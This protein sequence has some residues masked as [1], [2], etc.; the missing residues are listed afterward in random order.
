MINFDYRNADVSVIGDDH[1]LNISQVFSDY[2][3]KQIYR[4]L[5]SYE[6]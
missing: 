2:K 1:G 5:L 3:D 4:D 6:R